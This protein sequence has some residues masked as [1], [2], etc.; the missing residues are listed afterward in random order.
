MLLAFLSFPFSG[1]PTMVAPAT[2]TLG[3]C[4]GFAPSRGNVL[5]FPRRPSLLRPLNSHHKT[6]NLHEKLCFSSLPAVRAVAVDSDQLSSSEPV[7]EV[8]SSFALSLSVCLVLQLVSFVNR[9]MHMTA[10]CYRFGEIGMNWRLSTKNPFFLPRL[11]NETFIDE[12]E[13]FF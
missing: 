11:V 4:A 9:L 12:A 13:F 2:L 10:I 5:S 8:S 7:Q 3:P 6:R 1:G